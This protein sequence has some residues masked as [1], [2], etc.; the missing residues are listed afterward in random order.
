MTENYKKNLLNYIT[1]LIPGTPTAEEFS[2]GVNDVDRNNWVP[3]IPD[4]W[5]DF[6]LNGAI[7]SNTNDKVIFFGGYVEFG[8]TYSANSKGII[9]ITDNDL[10]PVQ[11]IYKYSSG[12]DLRPIACMIQEEDGQFVAIDTTSL[13]NPRNSTSRQTFQNCEKRF[14]MLNDM[15]I[16]IDNK[17]QVSLR[18]SFILGENYKNFV[19]KDIFKDPNSSHYLMMGTRI[20]LTNSV[21]AERKIKVIDLKVNVGSANEWSTVITSTDFV[22][23]GGY[24]YFDSSNNAEWKILISPLSLSDNTIRYWYGVNGTATDSSVIFTPSYKTYIDEATFECQSVFINENLVY[25][26]TNN[27]QWGISGVPETKYLGL[28]EFNFSTNT[29]KEVFLSNLGNYDYCN[30]GLIQLFAV[31]GELYIEYCTNVNN[32]NN[33]ANY[34]VQRYKGIWRPQLIFANANYVSYQRAF[35]ASQTFNLLK[36]YCI[37]INLRRNTWEMIEITDIYNLANYNG[38]QYD[39]YNSLKG[40]YGIIMSND[41][42]VFSRNL[43][44]LSITN[45]YTIASIEIPNT[46]LN[47]ME[48]SPKWLIGETKV[49]LVEDGNVVSKNIYEILYINFI[50]TINVKDN[51]SVIQTIPGRYIN[52]NINVGTEENY[53]NSKCTKVRVNYADNST[54]TFS[55]GWISVDDT[56]K[57]CEFTINVDKAISNIE[58]ISNDESTTYITIQRELEV[59]KAYTFKQYLK[60]E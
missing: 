24:C 1:E 31:N 11:S 5:Q 44:N 38:S 39:N 53:N 12:T 6:R 52:S 43:H 60:V 41:E 35:Y 37:P 29:L 40:R 33:T 9:I 2:V 58:L 46:Y 15:S 16:P 20:E 13:Y 3:F 8:G 32:E 14:I 56:H 51:E 25:F 19:C 34:C 21:Y 50:N 17:Y 27:Q 7:K 10:K 49:P 57:Y 59:G 30:L 23:G 54:R 4:Y 55:I 36:I 45:N 47:N 48:L 28:Y 26:S 22:Y 42:I 18:R